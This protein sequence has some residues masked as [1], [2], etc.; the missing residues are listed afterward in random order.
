MKEK[1]IMRKLSND[2]SSM[3]L[4]PISDKVRQAVRRKHQDNSEMVK[5]FPKSG[6]TNNMFQAKFVFAAML[7]LLIVSVPII[8]VLSNNVNMTELSEKTVPE[9]SRKLSS[10]PKS[11]DSESIEPE[12]SLSPIENNKSTLENIQLKKLYG[13]V[14][15]SE[16]NEKELETLLFSYSKENDVYEDNEYIYSFNSQ[17]NLIEVSRKKTYDE[18]STQIRPVVEQDISRKA[19]ALIKELFPDWQNTQIAIE[20]IPDG[21]PPWIVYITKKNDDLSMKQIYIAF[22]SP[23]NMIRILTAGMA[24]SFGNVS[25]EEAIKL[26]LNELKNDKYNFF[27]V[28]RDS[29]DITVDTTTV[30]GVEY[31]SVNV[32]YHNNDER[33]HKSFLFLVNPETGSTRLLDYS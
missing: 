28:E 10:E 25:R 11:I 4:P 27:D 9:S 30:S 33:I 20:E 24:E 31:Y 32:L 6:M 5:S 3:E 16:K 7:L 8:V 18:S 12:P 26:V 22:D 17:G 2:I 14:A 1:E 21:Y 19:D 23:G 29:L 15:L 13:D